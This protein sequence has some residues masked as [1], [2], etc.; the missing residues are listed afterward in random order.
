M[1][2][3]V[4]GRKIYNYRGLRQ[5][6]PLL[7]FIL[8]MEPLQQLFDLVTNR[9]LLS[10]LARSGL[11]QS[12]SMFADDVMVFLKP[13]E[14]ELQTCAR[15]LEM[16]GVASGLQVNVDKSVAIPIRCLVEGMTAITS[17]L[18]CPIGSF[19]CK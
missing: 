17:I 10:P 19:P 6:D 13:K 4:P 8:C 5:G 9:G 3:G 11:K 15:V 12:V 1:V 16:Y 2:N 7:L 18:G 14:M